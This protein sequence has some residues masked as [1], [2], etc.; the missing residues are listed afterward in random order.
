MT[1]PTVTQGGRRIWWLCA[2]LLLAALGG[3]TAWRGNRLSTL[4]QQFVG[5]WTTTELY[6]DGSTCTR[7]WQLRSDRSLHYHN[8]YHWVAAP[9]RAANTEEMKGV[10][11]WS[12]RDGR[13]LLNPIHPTAKRLRVLWILARWRV[14][15]AMQGVSGIVMDYEGSN[16]RLSAV[17]A[18]TF[19]VTWWEPDKQ[20]EY[21]TV[22]FTRVVNGPKP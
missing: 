10:M 22:V 5:Q 12:I 7:T 9:G 20:M 1:T 18:E 21:D 6:E 16:G 2:L 13:L 3:L 14:R 19:T 4:E 11:N 15:N 8:L 17:G